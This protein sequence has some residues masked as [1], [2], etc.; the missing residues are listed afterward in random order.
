MKKNYYPQYPRPVPTQ[1]KNRMA[2]VFLLGDAEDGVASPE[3]L[4]VLPGR[5]RVGQQ[6]H[7][8]PLPVVQVLDRLVLRLQL[9]FC[10]ARKPSLRVKL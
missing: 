3:D 5:V 10:G 4:R 9:Q 2:Y 6:T 7:D 8:L 1:E